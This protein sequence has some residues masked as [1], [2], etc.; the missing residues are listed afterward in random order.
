MF[1]SKIEKYRGILWKNIL[2]NEAQNN[3]DEGNPTKILSN[4]V[5]IICI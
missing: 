1:S 5:K 2:K 4:L 3:I